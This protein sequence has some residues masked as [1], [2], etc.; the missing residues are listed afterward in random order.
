[1]PN[2]SPSGTVNF[3]VARRLEEVAQ[4]LEAQGA[5]RYR[6]QAYRRAADTLRQQA[7]PVEALL[8]REGEAGLRRLPGIGERLARSI[9]TLI[10][11]G[12]LPMLDRLR[13]ASDANTLLASVPGIGK[14]LATRLRRDLNIQTLEE[15][16]A[17][18]HDGR[19]K[20]IAGIGPKKLSGIIDSL[21]ARLNY[22]RRPR[23]AAAASPPSV[24]ELLDVDREYREKASAGALPT[25]APRRFNPQR[26]A[27]L[28]ILHT[29]RGARHYTALFSNSARAHQL[30]TTKDWVVLYYDGPRGEDQC[31]VIT[32][33]H[34]PL[35]AKRIV[36]GRESECSDYYCHT[37]A[38]LSAGS[39]PLAARAASETFL[40]VADSQD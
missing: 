29:T 11:T 36:R 14:R 27:W 28:P 35:F 32:S 21:T 6:V 13:G 39:Y 15:L 17:A 12:R 30:Q 7:Q 19:L 37:T 10:L 18:A 34:E 2:S 38:T 16:E 3:R 23:A 5:N 9:S 31:T 4:L 22:V 24:A 26:E 40:Q 25:I 8:R 20:D 1:M 33:R